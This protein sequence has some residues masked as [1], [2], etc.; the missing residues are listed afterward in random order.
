[1]WVSWGFLWQWA[2][3]VRLDGGG[4]GGEGRRILVDVGARAVCDMVTA[5]YM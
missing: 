5:L 4:V 2:R 3:A 1:M